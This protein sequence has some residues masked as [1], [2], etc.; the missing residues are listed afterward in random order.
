MTETTC[1]S[2][3]RKAKFGVEDEPRGAGHLCPG[4]ALLMMPRSPATTSCACAVVCTM[5]T[6]RSTAAATASA[7]SAFAAPRAMSRSI[8]P[9][10]MSCT[11]SA[12]PALTRLSAIGPPMFPSPMN[13]TFPAIPPSLAARP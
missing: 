10:S 1:V 4:A 5:Q 8:F 13:P 7:D 12:K 2:F 11:T 3:E 6:V 9:A